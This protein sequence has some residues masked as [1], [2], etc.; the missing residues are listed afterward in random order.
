MATDR[1]IKKSV[2]KKIFGLVFPYKKKFVWVVILGLLG[3]GASLLE[4]LIY[5]EAVNDVAGL[6]VKQAKDS[7]QR[8]LGIDPDVEDPISSFLEKETGA[9]EKDTL[10]EAGDAATASAGGTT[11]VESHRLIVKKPPDSAAR[12]MANARAAVRHHLQHAPAKK[13]HRKKV[14]EPHT[15]GHVAARSPEQAL[16]TLLW[17]VVLLFLINLLATIFWRI[18]ENMN[19][20]LS[21]LI[22]QRFIQHTFSHVLNLPLQFFGKRSSAA[23]AKQIDQSEEVSGIVNG[24][25]QQI[26]PETISLLGILAIMFWE[27]VA[28]TTVAL[29]TIPFYLLIAW[30]SAR[31]LESGLSGY[32]EKWEDVS[33]RI[34]DGLTGIKTVKLSGAEDRETEQLQSISDEAYRDYIDRSRLSNK[35]VFW[36]TMLSH[37]STALVLGYGGYL[38]LQNKLTP[39]DVVMFVSYLDRLYGPID[40]LASL[41]VGL[42][43]NIASIARAFKLL[44]SGVEE[45]SGAPLVIGHGK[46]EFRDIWFS[47]D[48]KREILKGVSFL[49]EPGK[50]TALIGTSGAGKT[51]TVDLLMKLY[52]PSQ[53]KILI[54][55]QDL[56][57][58]D[59][60]SVRSQ[61]GMVSTDGAIFRGT[62]ADNI[63]YKRPEATLEEVE[64]AA[65]SAG[66]QATLQRLPDGL[67]TIVGESGIGLSVGERQRIQIAR[68]LVARPRI[69]VLDE[70]TANLDYA[71]EAEVKKTLE[72]IRKENTVIIIAHRY[73]MVHDADHVIVLS[74]G[75]VVEEGSPAELLTKAGWFADFANAAE[76]ETTTAQTEENP[77]EDDPE[78]EGSP[79]EDMTEEQEEESDSGEEE[80]EPE[81]DIQ[82]N[83]EEE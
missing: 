66:M 56:A 74:E 8:E 68:V 43:Q 62:L 41:W 83:E 13:T 77:A 42:Q 25:S 6:F 29:V 32:Y 46:I 65:L 35:Y 47:Y 9:G 53:G 18:G 79:E 22:E 78:E 1:N 14:K 24:F 54:D 26:L 38:T 44:D 36:E 48:G 16:N 61:I 15:Q 73:S 58:L 59:A 52:D 45:K 7:A 76:E 19:V 57:E 20:R 67:E 31:R 5:R 80:E 23:I 40:T 81:E 37:L 69:L 39:G 10:K 3:T 82:E 28:L 75:Q 34:Q 64:K 33:A 55:G 12:R 30:K 21:C 49:L 2:W 63:R 72:E 71:T 60:S 11:A 17:A 50:A 51:T 70:A 27:N 4:P